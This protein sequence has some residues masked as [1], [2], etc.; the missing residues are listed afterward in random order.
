MRGRP[1]PRPG[2]RLSSTYTV[3]L[4]CASCIKSQCNHLTGKKDPRCATLFVIPTPES[5]SDGKIDVKIVLILS[6]PESPS[7]SCYQLPIK[8]NQPDDNLEVLDDNLEELEK[9]TQFF[10]ASESDFVQGLKTDKKWLA[11]SSE[12]KDISQQPQAI[13][14]LLYVKN[15]NSIQPQTPAPA[16]SS[17]SSSSGSSFSSSSS[18][19]STGFSSPNPACKDPTPPP[20]SGYVLANVKSHHRLPPGVSWLQFIR[21]TGSE[22]TKTRQSAPPKPKPMRSRNTKSIKKGKRGPNTLLRYFQTKFQNEKS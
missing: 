12:D 9:I 10:P 8:D 16:P 17:S 1:N 4:E 19:S 6:L 5:S 3:C 22:T 18:S 13:D 15:S 21:S 7:S 11:V 20:L 14:W 2:P